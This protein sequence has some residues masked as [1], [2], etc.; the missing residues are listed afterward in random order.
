SDLHASELNGQTRPAAIIV[1]F[2][3]EP[4]PVPTEAHKTLPAPEG[5]SRNLPVD[6]RAEADADSMSN[7]VTLLRQSVSEPAAPSLPAAAAVATPTGPPA[8]QETPSAPTQTASIVPLT[9]PDPKAAPT[10]QPA[11]SQA[12]PDEATSSP[13]TKAVALATELATPEVVTSASDRA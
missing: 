6:D 3:L 2:D 9:R 4:L 13:K 5:R 8:I 11:A 7:V 12:S 1:Q 10:P